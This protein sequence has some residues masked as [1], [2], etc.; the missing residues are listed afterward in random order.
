MNEPVHLRGEPPAASRSQPGDRSDRHAGRR[1]ADSGRVAFAVSVGAY[2]V[3]DDAPGN[4]HAKPG[5]LRSQHPT[6]HTALLAGWSL[7]KLEGS[8]VCAF[9]ASDGGPEILW[10]SARPD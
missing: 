7:N 8:A 4:D 5:R 2:C 9:R 1:T 3:A 6:L 10:R